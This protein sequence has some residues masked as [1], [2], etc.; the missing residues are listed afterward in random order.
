MRQS[1]AVEELNIFAFELVT[2]GWSVRRQKFARTQAARGRSGCSLRLNASLNP[3]GLK[4]TEMKLSKNYRTMFVSM[5]PSFI[6]V[7]KC[8]AQSSR[9]CQEVALLYRA[10]F[11]AE[12]SID[13]HDTYNLNIERGIILRTIQWNWFWM[14]GIFFQIFPLCI[15]SLQWETLYI[16]QTIMETV[17]IGTPDYPL[18]NLSLLCLTW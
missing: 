1:I 8:S 6:F 17:S 2:I 9:W 5:N 12:W 3:L 4:R 7:F 10:F 14:N 13:E 18:D 16:F 11:S 15:D